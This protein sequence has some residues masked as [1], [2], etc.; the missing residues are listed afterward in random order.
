MRVLIVG[1][2]PAG[3]LSAMAIGKKHDILIVEEH[4]SAGFPVQCAGLISE[5]CYGRLR[6]YSKCKLN[7]IRGAFFIAPNGE[8]VELEG[9]CRGIV[10]E[11]K[12]LDRDLLAKASE[13]AEIWV[14]SKF[15]DARN[16]KAEI[17]QLG[18]RTTIEFDAMIGADGAYS[19]V[20]RCFNFERPEILSAVQ[21]ECR[22]EALSDDMVELFFGKSYSDGFFAYAIP[23][24]ENARVGVV[25]RSNPK[26]YLENLIKKH[27]SASRRIVSSKIIELNAGAIPVGL[28]DFVKDNIAL[29]GDSAGMV[30]PYTGGG[31]FYLLRATEILK[32]TFPNLRKF[33]EE[34]LKSIGRE[35]SFGMK[36]Y[37]LYSKLEDEDYNYI[38]RMAKDHTHLAKELHMDCPST[39]LRVLPTII[40]IVRKPKLLKKLLSVLAT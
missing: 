37:R 13:F 19:A 7:D 28:V 3:S 30:K 10:I 21:I 9:K 26:F 35:I 25:S 12:I 20:A 2:G 31:L 34:Y 23:L 5:D 22:Y 17:L 14:K 39:L 29:I 33:K 4:Q 16:G 1:A 11:R 6:R 32:E 36:I 38:V 40:K 27:P 15:V 18:N 8:A 24:D